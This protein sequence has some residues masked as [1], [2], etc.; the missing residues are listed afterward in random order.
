MGLHSVVRSIVVDHARSV[1]ASHIEFVNEIKTLRPA[2]LLA[3]RFAVL[4]VSS[5]LFALLAALPAPALFTRVE[6]ASVDDGGFGV[7]SGTA[8]LAAFRAVELGRARRAGRSTWS[9]ASA[10]SFSHALSLLFRA[11]GAVACTGI[12][13]AASRGR[14]WRGS[15]L[16]IGVVDGEVGLGKGRIVSKLHHKAPEAVHVDGSMAVV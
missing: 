14:S 8:V 1:D 15:S 7:A 3:A 9:R 10:R 5:T 11:R 12:G 6:R 16:L 13:A 4:A 2:D